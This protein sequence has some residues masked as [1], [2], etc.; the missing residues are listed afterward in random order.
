MPA[1]TVKWTGGVD[2]DFDNRNNWD[3]KIVPGGAATIQDTIVIPRTASQALTTNLDRSALGMPAT[4]VLTLAANAGNTE[5]VTLD[6][7]VYTWQ[8]S[9]TDSDGNVLIGASA[10]ASIDNLVAAI[11][12]GSGAGTTYAASTTIHPT[13]SAYAGA[14]D[15]MDVRQCAPGVSGVTSA[16]TMANGSFAAGTLQG[17]TTTGTDVALLHVEDGAPAIGASGTPLKLGADKITF[18]GRNASYITNDGGSANHNITRLI[19]DS[20]N[21]VD[22]LTLSDSDDTELVSTLEIISGAV[23]FSGA[24]G[25]STLRMASASGNRKP[26]LTV[27]SAAGTLSVVYLQAGALTTAAAITNCYV[28]GGTLTSTSTV[29]NMFQLGG[30]FV[31]N[32]TTV[33]SM[34][35]VA[36]TM[37][38]TQT[39]GAK[40]LTLLRRYPA[41]RLIKNDDFL[42]AS[43]TVIGE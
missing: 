24:K 4:G 11:T 18:H 30:L 32:G 25:I 16:E 9:L 5:T 17:W 22:A 8:T 13:V 6:A 37:D 27:T 19:V 36:G 12:L 20:K 35:L 39:P 3:L 21:L 33:S 40:T 10:S 38:T 34:D 28:A 43:E 42:T 1:Q 15:T 7:K 41:A 14:G 31:F 2:G 29:G 23:T 26:R